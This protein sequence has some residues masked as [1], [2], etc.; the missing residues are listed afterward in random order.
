MKRQTKYYVSTKDGAYNGGIKR[1]SDY[2]KTEIEARIYFETH[3]AYYDTLFLR[4]LS[5]D[6]KIRRTLSTY[7]GEK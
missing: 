3:K 5:P 2:L 7:E 6:N 1:L 4:C